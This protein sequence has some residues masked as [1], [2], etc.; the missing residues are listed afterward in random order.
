MSEHRDTVPKSGE[1]LTPKR[2]PVGFALGYAVLGAPA[3]WSLQL[4]IQFP[5]AAHA[6]YPNNVP[7]AQPLWSFTWWMLIGIEFIALIAAGLGGF[8]AVSKWMAYRHIDATCTGLRRNQYLSWWALLTSGLFSIAIIFT[9][10]M[11]F[12]EPICDV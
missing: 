11:I 12:I 10:V 6:C 4:L 7:L 1:P 9:I 5:L 2:E 8:L 3:A